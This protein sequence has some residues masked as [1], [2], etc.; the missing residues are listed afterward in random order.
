MDYTSFILSRQ[1]QNA[2]SAI[3]IDA[4]RP[5]RSISWQDYASAI[6]RIAVGLT[7][8]GVGR[9]ETVGLVSGND[10]YF[11]VLADGVVAA[12]AT[13]AAI[14][15]SLKETDLVSCM[16]A[17]KVSWLCASPE[18]LDMALAAAERTGVDRCRV[19]VFDPPGRNRDPY[20]GPQPRFSSLL[21][22]SD[23]S[24]W[25]NPNLGRDPTTIVAL[26]QF[27][28]GT[29]GTVKA[30]DVCHDILVE[31]VKRLDTTGLAP[32]QQDVA[33]LD[34]IP[35]FNVGGQMTTAKAVLGKLPA[36]ITSANDAATILDK[37]HEF[38]VT[39]VQLTVPMM[40]EIRATIQAGTRP[41][42]RLGSLQSVLVGGAPSRKEGVEAFTRL[43]PSHAI[44]RSGY[45]STE[46][47]SIALTPV[48]SHWT[49]GYVGFLVDDVELKIIDPETLETLS[50][51]TE[52]EICVRS[53]RVMRSYCN[54]KE[55]TNSVFLRPDPTTQQQPWFR[56][57]DKGYLDP[58]NGQLA[59][60][61]RFKEIFKVKSQHV[62]PSEVEDELRKHP[63]IADA[64]VTSVQARVGGGDRECIAYVVREKEG[65]GDGLT[66]H[67]V[68]DFVASRLAS[69]KAPTGGVVFCE[70]ILRNDNG[71]IMR[72]KLAGISP[73][74]G[75]AEYL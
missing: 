31:R 27:T 16:A 14:A 7:A 6:R 55:A 43:L 30:V 39:L 4:D 48:D 53:P 21:A 42:D 41:R 61:G 38:R 66:A 70:R 46:T 20:R 50:S 72:K 73:L 74:A 60:T 59:V 36:Y 45:G 24:L 23:G 47:A 15:T 17:G 13:F 67:E 29:T 56:T 32:L 75:S 33:A 57:G 63:S 9:Q 64:A 28:S 35:M 26:R 52:G 62:S 71:K 49:P 51:D 22:D 1:P 18:H 69:H 44:L 34:Y 19:I 65:R 25:R 2:A 37:I 68:L 8:L 58:T 40:E 54:D 5:H 3:L 12:G 10:P 11:Y